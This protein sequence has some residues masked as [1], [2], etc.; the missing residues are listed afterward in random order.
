MGLEEIGGGF[1]GLEADGGGGGD[2]DGG[3]GEG[4]AEDGVVELEF[5]EG[6]LE[7][8]RVGAA[9]EEE[10]ED[11]DAGAAGDGSAPAELGAA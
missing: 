6:A 5:L 8:G 10:G 2:G 11:G 3:G 7:E 4:G 1:Q 9:G